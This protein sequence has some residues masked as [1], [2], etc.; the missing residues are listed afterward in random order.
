[1]AIFYGFRP[2]IQRQTVLVPPSSCVTT[3]EVDDLLS[4]RSE[5]TQVKRRPR[6]L[7]AVT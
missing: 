7:W 1:M 5:E 2:D 3:E 4:L 6:A